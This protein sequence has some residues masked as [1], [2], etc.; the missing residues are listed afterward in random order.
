[1]NLESANPSP[2]G[3]GEKSARAESIAE[4]LWRRKQ[5]VVVVFLLCLMAAAVALKAI[6]K[7][8]TVVSRVLVNRNLPANA[9][10]NAADL[11][12]FL[13]TQAELI[14]SATVLSTAMGAPGLDQLS[15]FN[16]SD[17]PINTLKD[18][19]VVNPQ[20][21]SSI[22]DIQL[23]STKPDEATRIVSAVAEAYTAYIADQKRN[24]ALNTY[25]QIAD[26]RNRLDKQRQDEKKYELSLAA[27]M[28]AA[29][30]GTDETQNAAIQKNRQLSDDLNDAHSRAMTLQS[31]Y[32]E[33]LKAI[34][35][36]PDHV[37][38]NALA[39]A[40]AVSPQSLP[41]LQSN[42]AALNQQLME[43]RRQ[44]VVTHPA[45]RAIKA[46]IK[47]LQLSQAATLKAMS[48]AADAKEKTARQL[49]LEQDQLVRN[50]NAKAAELG[51]VQDH[52]RI[53]DGQLAALDKKLQQ[54]TINESV[55]ID[56][57]E[58]DDA[59][60]D[61]LSAV[62][63]TWKTLGL[64]SMIG[65]A[66]GMLT[67]V[68]REWI[69]PSLGAIHRIADTVGV[70][71]LGTLPHLPG[72]EGRDVAMITHEDASS[73]AAEAF[74]S[75]RT[76]LLFGAAHCQTITVTS[77]AAKD[78]KTTLATNLAISLAQSGKSVALVDANF[79]EPALHNIFEVDNAI[80]LTGVLD[81]EDLESSLRRT[82]IE[83]LDILTTGPKTTDVS[84]Q[85]NSERF[86]ELLR[87]LCL[88]YDHVIFD[89]SSVTGSNDARVIA[90]G[91]DATILVA[92]E[93][94]TNR[95]A[96]TNAREAL[97]SV[98]AQLMGIVLNDSAKTTKAYPAGVDRRTD[99]LTAERSKELIARLR[100]RH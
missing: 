63:N 92:R 9:D 62:P 67:A 72:S 94:R 41:L 85:L 39:N 3:S 43:A 86:T 28:R 20:P 24:S 56:A 88:R 100:A 57:K 64:A 59:S 61:P 84:E 32:E 76:S 54:L 60:V 34:G 19:L 2:L 45:V 6:P 8:M 83:H 90:A 33:S 78:G 53:L 65:L 68:A 5:I 70:P 35:M 99:T 26:D 51:S 79:R 10:K 13:N 27:E 25:T 44:F 46:Q 7:R 22:I 69:S 58:I 40:T 14:R 49:F 89:T 47:D 73:E 50:V 95:F 21:Q 66:L 87:D 12:T 15:F 16:G 29:G 81:G 91:C 93:E 82:P 31:Q 23:S 71:V 52:I 4:I 98:G 11:P 48:E 55:G 80:G 77:P 17:N 97:L 30:I 38:T 42:L 36:S 1:M 37:D 18:H 74:R 96:A 75:I